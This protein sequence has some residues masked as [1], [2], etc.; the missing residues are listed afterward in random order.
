MI[1]RAKF[2]GPQPIRGFQP[3]VYYE[4]RLRGMTVCPTR[5]RGSQG[6]HSIKYETLSQFLKHW[7][8]ESKDTSD[9]VWLPPNT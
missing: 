5:K 7:E 2:V 8:V 9:E 3:D 6:P 4:I 1:V